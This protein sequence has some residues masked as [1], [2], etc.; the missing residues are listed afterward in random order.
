VTGHAHR[1]VSCDRNSGPAKAGRLST[2]LSLLP[3]PLACPFLAIKES[4][5]NIIIR[6]QRGRGAA[7]AIAGPSRDARTETPDA[8]MP[9]TEDT[10]DATTSCVDEDGDGDGGRD[11]GPGYGDGVS[12]FDGPPDADVEVEADPTPTPRPRGRPRGRGRGR[13]ALVGS[14]RAWGRVPWEGPWTWTWSRG[15]GVYDI[16]EDDPK[17]D[18]KIDKHESLLGGALL[19]CACRPLG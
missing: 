1:I 12:A 13:G 10:E 9:A 18:T 14:T 3:R 8:G 19:R 2:L 16:T 15:Q 7:P 6:P 5:G 4:S 17:G 11:G